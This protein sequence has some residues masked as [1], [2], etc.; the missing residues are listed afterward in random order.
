MY[1]YARSM[2]CAR[3]YNKIDW[4]KQKDEQTQPNKIIYTI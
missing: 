1:L 4:N 2:A 3:L